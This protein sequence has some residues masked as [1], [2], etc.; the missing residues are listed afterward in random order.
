METLSP[1]RSSCSPLCPTEHPEAGPGR[2]RA[3]QFHQRGP[4]GSGRGKG[5]IGCL[6]EAAT[7]WLCRSPHGS[8]PHAACLDPPFTPQRPCKAACGDGLCSGVW[9]LGPRLP[10]GAGGSDWR[11]FWS[12]CSWFSA[13]PGPRWSPLTPPGA[14][15][16]PHRFL[17]GPRPAG[18]CAQGSSGHSVTGC[19]LCFEN[20]WHW[21]SL[22]R[23][24]PCPWSD[25]S[26][27]SRLASVP[28]GLPGTLLGPSAPPGE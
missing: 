19:L 20:P 12:V 9:G 23:P 16:A 7:G 5:T 21:G 14:D 1:D 3:G 4:G 6:W 25:L 10:G 18:L 27:L 24:L 22:S 17:H 11:R 13:H 2:L 8:S 15:S 28:C 26:L